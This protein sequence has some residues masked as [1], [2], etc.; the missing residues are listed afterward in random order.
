MFVSDYGRQSLFQ[1]LSGL[2]ASEK[3]V[4]KAWPSFPEKV[5]TLLQK[6]PSLN[7]KFRGFQFPTFVDIGPQHQAEFNSNGYAPFD[8]KN[9]KFY[10]LETL[11]VDKYLDSSAKHFRF[12]EN[13][14]CFCYFV[15]IPS[16]LGIVVEKD[17]NSFF[18]FSKDVTCIDTESNR[19]RNVLYYRQTFSDELNENHDEECKTFCHE[20]S[21]IMVAVDHNLFSD[22]WSISASLLTGYARYV[23][24]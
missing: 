6:N 1:P 17:L 20:N 10:F 4:C 3:G 21:C 18:E 16:W 15:Q 19:T 5:K 23:L 7:I 2:I 22:K 9:N 24:D 12:D 13:N 11:N 8:S 14:S